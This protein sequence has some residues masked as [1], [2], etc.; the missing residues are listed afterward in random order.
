MEPH[1][2]GW[3]SLLPPIVAIA[4]AIATRRIVLSLVLGIFAGALVM[5][6]GDPLTAI[7]HTWETHLWSTLI[8]PSKMRMLSFTLL[9]GGMVGVITR[10]G[11]ME[12][13]VKLFT[14]YASNR[15]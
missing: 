4:L 11:G 7:G 8:D 12:G 6:G 15:R 1:P 9:M 10:S 14:P 13:M 2:F 3:M 5:S